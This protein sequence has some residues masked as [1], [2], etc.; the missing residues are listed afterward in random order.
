MIR[1]KQRASA[2]TVVELLVVIAIIGTLVGLILPAVGMVRA[3]ARKTQCATYMKQFGVAEQNFE[4]SA[5]YMSASRGWPAN[6]NI[7]RPAADLSASATNNNAQSWVSPLLPHLEQVALYERLETASG[8]LAA[9]FFDN[10][11]IPVV[12]CPSDISDMSAANRSSYVANG[13]RFNGQPSGNNP[14]D[15]QANG[16]LDDRLKG[17]GQT[18]QIFQGPQGMSKAELVRGDGASNTLLFLENSDVMGWN[19]AH[20]ERDVA[21]VW[22]TSNP[23]TNTN[24]LNQLRRKTGDSFTNMHARPSS[25]HANGFNVTF[26]DGTVKFL[27]EAIDYGVYCQL[28]TSN[29]RNLKEPSTNNASS[30]SLPVLTQSSY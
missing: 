22:D 23:P 6:A 14:L 24:G 8:N 12:Y 19:K 28:M 9:N 26:A 13:G 18:F 10:D 3:A 4:T 1:A 25:F 20:N 5:G 2:F 11:R 21:V 27:A 16:C 15:W 7:S 29:S 17:M 30:V